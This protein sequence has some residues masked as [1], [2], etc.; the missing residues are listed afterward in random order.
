MPQTEQHVGESQR[1]VIVYGFDNTHIQVSLP[2]GEAAHHAQIQP[3]YFAVLHT[4]IARVRVGMEKPVGGYL[5][6]VVVDKLG[7][8]LVQIVAPGCKPGGV[9]YLEAVY[10]L[11]DKDVSGGK[12][13]YYIGAAHIGHIPVVIPEFL[14][15]PGLNSEIQLLLQSLPHLVQHLAEIQR[16]AYG[17]ILHKPRGFFHQGDVPLHG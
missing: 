15:I 4:D 14:N 17:G 7:G 12:L 11:H 1:V 9:V 2:L 13:G 16:A 3:D 8:D 6:Y 5:L 10:A